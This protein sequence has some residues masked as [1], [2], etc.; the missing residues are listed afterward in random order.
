MLDVM[1]FT[2][3]PKPPAAASP[4][5]NPLPKPPSVDD[6]DTKARMAQAEVLERQRRKTSSTILT[7]AQGVLNDAP[8]QLK[9][10]F[11]N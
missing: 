5:Q 6:A 4:A 10:L 8:V 9:Q 7:S 1:G 11:G 3:P 2:P